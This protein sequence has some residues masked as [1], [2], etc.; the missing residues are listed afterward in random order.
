MSGSSWMDNHHLEMVVNKPIIVCFY[1][2][3]S[4]KASLAWIY[5]LA[6]DKRISIFPTI[7][8]ETHPMSFQK[9][10]L[11][12]AWYWNHVFC[13]VLKSC[14]SLSIECTYFTWYWM[15]Y[16]MYKRGSLDRFAYKGLI[17][18]EVNSPNTHFYYSVVWIFKKKCFFLFVCLFGFFF[19]KGFSNL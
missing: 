9:R 17:V 3:N 6:S 10:T 13:M 19:K 15:H 12:F 8:V 11:L 18:Q 7:S 2:S 5:R 16:I 14:I 4:G 1:R